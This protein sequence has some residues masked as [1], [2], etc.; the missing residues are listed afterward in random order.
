MSTFSQSGH[1]FTISAACALL[2][3]CGASQPPIGT[4]GALP[5]TA[6]LATHADR[7]KSWMLPEAQGR[8]LLY[9]SK[10]YYPG[11]RDV[12]V[13]TYPGA[14][15][16]GMLGGLGEPEG[17][18]VDK[19]ANVF[20]ADVSSVYEYA[21]GGTSPI[22][23]INSPDGAGACSIDLTTEKL[24]ATSRT[25]SGAAISTFA[26]QPK[27]GWRFPKII[28]VPGMAD[29]SFCGYDNKGNLFVDGLS[30]ARTFVMAEL[31]KGSASFTTIAL[32]Q[33]ITEPGQVQWD[34]KHLAVGD[35][36][37]SP[38]VIY[39]F[40]IEGSNGTEVG[41]TTLGGSME[42][43]QFWIQGGTIIGPSYD[44]GSTPGVGFWLYPGGGNVRQTITLENPFGATVSLAK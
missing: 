42:V 8:N 19:A 36:G 44:F 29:A 24:A 37:L 13:Y 39:R 26:Y 31:P 18:C 25:T 23:I 40:S 27:R 15:L 22:A 4:S 14:K 7:G 21:H 2:A 28:S 1:A 11:A 35:S 10:P 38:S 12:Y 17:E 20:V 3:G 41:A 30:S 6:V 5:Q 16:V 43:K 34:G 32:N 33:N 9:I